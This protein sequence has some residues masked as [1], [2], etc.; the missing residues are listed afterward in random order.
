M[1]KLTRELGAEVAVRE[2]VHR[3]LPAHEG[4][5]ERVVGPG[6]GIE[7]LEAS[8]LR[9]M[10]AGGV[11]V[12]P[13]EPGG[14]VVD[15]GQRVEIARIALLRDVAIAEEVGHTLPERYPFGPP[16]APDARRHTRHAARARSRAP[17]LH[18]S[19]TPGT[20][21]RRRAGAPLPVSGFPQERLQVLVNDRIED[22]VLSV[23]GPIQRRGKSHPR[24][25]RGRGRVPMRKDGY[26][27][28]EPASRR[29]ALGPAQRHGRVADRL[30][31]G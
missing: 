30:T 31:L 7:G 24:A 25:Y 29:A 18:T 11:G 21:A 23:T 9:R 27:G 16:P 8:G 14:G 12:R 19:G 6:H 13:P 20:R 5:E 1:S 2:A 15:L 28:T 4:D 17:T 3:V 22:G 26:T 10:L